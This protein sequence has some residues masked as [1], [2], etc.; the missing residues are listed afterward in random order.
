MC[1][2]SP[3]FSPLRG[4]RIRSRTDPHSRSDSLTPSS[5]N[6]LGAALPPFILLLLNLLFLFIFLPSRDSDTP[7]L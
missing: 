1:M 7:L 2:W 5:P 6:S 3:L 4:Q